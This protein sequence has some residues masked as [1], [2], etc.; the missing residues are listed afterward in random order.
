[1]D[2][3]WNKKLVQNESLESTPVI[4]IISEEQSSTKHFHLKEKIVESQFQ[5]ISTNKGGVV[6]E[7]IHQYKPCCILLDI[8]LSDVDGWKVL[9]WL[10]ND[11]QTRPIPVV[12]T[13]VKENERLTAYQQGAFKV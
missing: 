1:M 2:V 12:M 7:L 13:S 3:G 6:F 5:V 11:L 9:N 4:L 10:K 8:H